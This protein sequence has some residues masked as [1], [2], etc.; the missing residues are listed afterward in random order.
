MFDAFGA[1]APFEVVLTGFLKGAS[2][3]NALLS[4]LWIQ[5]RLDSINTTTPHI[6]HKNQEKNIRA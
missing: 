2:S 4:T 3:D 6:I 1:Y 5:A